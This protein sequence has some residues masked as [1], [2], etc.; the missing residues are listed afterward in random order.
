MRVHVS[1]QI[2]SM[3]T[4]KRKAFEGERPLEVDG[5]KP[6]P[7]LDLDVADKPQDEDSRPT[8]HF[9]ALPTKVQGM[10]F[11]NSNLNRDR[12][13]YPNHVLKMLDENGQFVQGIL[14]SGEPGPSDGVCPFLSTPWTLPCSLTIKEHWSDFTHGPFMCTTRTPL[15]LDKFE[16]KLATAPVHEEQK[17]LPEEFIVCHTEEGVVLFSPGTNS[18]RCEAPPPSFTNYSTRILWTWTPPT[19]SP[20]D[21]LDMKVCVDG[22]RIWV[23]VSDLITNTCAIWHF[24]THGRTPGSDLPSPDD[25]CATFPGSVTQ[26][27]TLQDSM[28]QDVLLVCVKPPAL[29]LGLLASLELYTVKLMTHE[30][31]FVEYLHRLIDERPIYEIMSRVEQ[32]EKHVAGNLASDSEVDLASQRS[33]RSERFQ[34]E[35]F[36]AFDGKIAAIGGFMQASASAN[37]NENEQNL[38]T[39]YLFVDEDFLF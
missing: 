30:D 39:R 2:L 27:V 14:P 20:G 1:V 3:S 38:D 31:F 5:K 37:G 9:A 25:P 11:L 6:R 28:R 32:I 34:I 36:A 18:L 23:A 4:L 22:G 21:K 26:I 16:Y 7:N 13:R 15:L 33:R 24:S 12:N 35:Q 10:Y 19:A 8:R 17:A 29:E